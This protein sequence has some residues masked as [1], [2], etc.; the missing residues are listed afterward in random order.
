M[1]LISSAY[2]DLL[3][4]I[5]VVLKQHDVRSTPEIVLYLFVCVIMLII[6]MLLT[7]SPKGEE[8]DQW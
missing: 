2:Q 6:V 7:S 4:R 5:D 3:H 8:N 1:D